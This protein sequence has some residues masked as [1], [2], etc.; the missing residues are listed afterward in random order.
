[1]V[2]AYN[3]YKQLGRVE[4]NQR[5]VYLVAICSGQAVTDL[6][7]VIQPIKFVMLSRMK[8]MNSVRVLDRQE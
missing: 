5:V 6:K 2:S 8:L 7:H 3:V 4:M 1:M